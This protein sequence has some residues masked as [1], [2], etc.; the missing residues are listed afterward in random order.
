LLPASSR[1]SKLAPLLFV[2]RPLISVIYPPLHLLSIYAAFRF[3]SEESFC[4]VTSWRADSVSQRKCNLRGPNVTLP[5]S[6]DFIS[7]FPCWGKEDWWV[8]ARGLQPLVS[9]LLLFLFPLM[10]P[11]PWMKHDS[12]A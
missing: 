7:I 8:L 3:A 10:T 11:S 2:M 6:G 1:R 5:V 12:P 9:R 4:E